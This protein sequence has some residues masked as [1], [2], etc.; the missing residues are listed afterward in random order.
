MYIIPDI[1]IDPTDIMDMIEDCIRAGINITTND[2]MIA[3]NTQI[4][5]TS[6]TPFKES[7]SPYTH[8]ALLDILD[9]MVQRMAMRSGVLSELKI[10]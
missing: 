1:I 2:A 6:C 4:L 5:G 9:I 3:I 7:I 10:N 8:S